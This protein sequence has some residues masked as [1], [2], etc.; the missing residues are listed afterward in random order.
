MSKKNIRPQ[1]YI[2]VQREN[3]GTTKG[4]DGNAGVLASCYPPCYYPFAGDDAE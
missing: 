4:K 2:P 1:Q 3:S